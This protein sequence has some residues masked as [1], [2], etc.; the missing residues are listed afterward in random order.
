V[1][2]TFANAEM[3]V[4]VRPLPARPEARQI[5]AKWLSCG[6]LRAVQPVAGRAEAVGD[7]RAASTGAT[8][9]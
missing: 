2:A 1:H 5:E 9:T 3:T 4:K 7:G 8:R 6:H